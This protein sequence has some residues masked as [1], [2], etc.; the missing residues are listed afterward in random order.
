MSEYQVVFEVA[1][2]KGGGQAGL[3]AAI[4]DALAHSKVKIQPGSYLVAIK[5]APDDTRTVRWGH[6]GLSFYEGSRLCG[7]ALSPLSPQG[8]IQ[9]PSGGPLRRALE[10]MG[11]VWKSGGQPQAHPDFPQT[12]IEWQQ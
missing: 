6:W 2:E 12:R 5:R 8:P 7:R 11:R 3:L 4:E 9:G 1:V 10:E